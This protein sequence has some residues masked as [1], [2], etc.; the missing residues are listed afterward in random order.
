MVAL[1]RRTQSLLN[2]CVL[3]AITVPAICSH[4]ALAQTPP[5]RFWL[6]GRYDWNRVLIYF[7]AV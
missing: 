5:E 6:A 1:L 7:D 2:Q 3:L 4:G